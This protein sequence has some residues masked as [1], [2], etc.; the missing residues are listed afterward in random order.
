MATRIFTDI[1]FNF[2]PHPI[3]G[4][5]ATRVNENA[6]KQSLR[7]LILTTN[8]ERPFQS[9]IGTPIKNMLFEHS[10]PLT[11]QIITR[12]IEDTVRNFEPRASLREV[13]VNLNSDNNSIDIRIE[14]TILNSSPLQVLNLTLERTR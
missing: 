12:A 7:S 3:S 5:V 4:D 1:D 9:Q 13:G 8:Y 11:Q 14:Y 10:S 6:V 2:K